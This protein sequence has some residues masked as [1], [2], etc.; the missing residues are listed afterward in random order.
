LRNL[1]SA[2]LFLGFSE[3]T[4]VQRD[5]NQTSARYRR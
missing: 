4:H 2:S 5:F 1:S 3:L